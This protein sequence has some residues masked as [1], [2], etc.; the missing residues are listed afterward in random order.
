[1]SEQV[2]IP[3]SVPRDED[4]FDE[5]I[6]EHEMIV[7]WVEVQKDGSVEAE[8]RINLYSKK[9]NISFSVVKLVKWRLDEITK[10]G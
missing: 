8:I 2:P 3:K 1:M 10:W 5:Y 4:I 6:S 7:H 9:L